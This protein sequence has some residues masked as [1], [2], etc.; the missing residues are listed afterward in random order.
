MVVLNYLRGPFPIVSY[1]YIRT[2]AGDIFNNRKVV[3]E[4]SMVK[5]YCTAATV[6]T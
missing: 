1:M 5:T 3:N 6:C 4:L 2:I